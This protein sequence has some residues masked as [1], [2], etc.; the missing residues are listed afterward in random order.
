MVTLST[1]SHPRLISLNI[2]I[3][4]RY[5][6]STNH[7]YLIPTLQPYSKTYGTAQIIQLQ[8]NIARSCFSISLIIK[9]LYNN[10]LHFM[11]QVYISQKIKKNIMSLVNDITKSK[12][13]ILYSKTKYSVFAPTKS[14]LTIT[15]LWCCSY[16]LILK[17]LHPKNDFF[18][19]KT[20]F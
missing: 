13:I 5:L 20:T 16:M 18:F 8:R 1:L 10:L 14:P 19:A 6:Y 12:L 15:P 11:D 4:Y 9:N 2:S 7:Y 3:F 17:W